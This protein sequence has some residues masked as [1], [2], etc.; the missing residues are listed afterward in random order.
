M[1]LSEKLAALEE[2]DRRSTKATGAANWLTRGGSPQRD[3]IVRDL[4][5]LLLVFS[6]TSRLTHGEFWDGVLEWTDEL[7]RSLPMTSGSGQRN[8]C[9]LDS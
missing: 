5:T 7:W 1:K 4:Q 9:K 8:V 6:R 3:V 2:E